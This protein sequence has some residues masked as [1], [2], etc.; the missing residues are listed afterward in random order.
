[1]NLLLF[2]FSFILWDNYLFYDKFDLFA[3]L[4]AY[5]SIEFY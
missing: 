5:F 2:L 1:M 3:L 4:L